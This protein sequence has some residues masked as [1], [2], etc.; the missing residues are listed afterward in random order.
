[1]LVLRVTP[2]VAAV[3][4][5]FLADLAAGWRAVTARG[6]LWTSLIVFSLSNL[7][8]AAFLVLG[9]VVFAEE[10]GGA[11]DWGLAMSLAGAGGLVGGAIALRV[12][13]Q[14]PLVVV[15][16]VWLALAAPLLAL[17]RPLP[18]IAVGLAAAA[19]FAAGL[20]GNAIWEATLQRH[21][22]GDILARVSSYDWLVSLIFTPLGF[23]LAGPTADAIGLDAT[24]LAAAGLLVVVHVAI[25]LVPSVRHLRDA[26]VGEPAQATA[27]A[28]S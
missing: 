12:R 8:N 27:T 4:Q 11:S 25:L 22:P 5:T 28:A 3:R 19:A 26:P 14:R 15:F 20:L 9:P 17:V 7:A 13:P 24:L 21:I 2:G 1:M 10:L 16:V 18:P 23:A 6:W